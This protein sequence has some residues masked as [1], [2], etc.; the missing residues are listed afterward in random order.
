[1]FVNEISLHCFVVVMCLATNVEATIDMAPVT[2][3]KISAPRC[4]ASVLA[5]FAYDNMVSRFCILLW[6]VDSSSLIASSLSCSCVV[7][8]CGEIIRL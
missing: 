3:G 6:L 8:A 4:N 5:M 1:M 7:V 2:F